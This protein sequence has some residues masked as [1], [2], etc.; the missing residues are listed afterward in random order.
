MYG[1]PC[2]RWIEIGSEKIK[3]L[4]VRCVDNRGVFVGTTVD[5]MTESLQLVHVADAA[6]SGR[7]LNSRDI[8]CMCGS[9]HTKAPTAA[10]P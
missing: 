10:S 4:C 2:A 3:R 8:C 7:R 9:F 6:D 5:V 1:K